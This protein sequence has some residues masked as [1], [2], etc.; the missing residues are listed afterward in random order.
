MA[1]YAVPMHKHLHATR[2]VLLLPLVTEQALRYDWCAQQLTTP[3]PSAIV[4]S[5]SSGDH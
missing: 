5:C 1:G 3:S 4:R 2:D